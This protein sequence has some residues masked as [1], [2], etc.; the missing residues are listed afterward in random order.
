MRGRGLSAGE[1]CNQ[2]FPHQPTSDQWF[3]ESQFE[4]YRQLGYW[5]SQL[6]LPAARGVFNSIETSGFAGEHRFD[7]D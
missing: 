1:G 5:I 7:S 3:T 2:L 4:S 6:A